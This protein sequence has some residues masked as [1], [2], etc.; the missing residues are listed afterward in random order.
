M[1]LPSLYF[2]KY[3]LNIIIY[4]DPEDCLEQL[5]IFKMKL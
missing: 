5:Q 3:E 1:I 4:H 2:P